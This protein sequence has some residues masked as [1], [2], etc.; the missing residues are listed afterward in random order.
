MKL[1]RILVAL[2]FAMILTAVNAEAQAPPAPLLVSPA[3]GA[4][5]AQPLT[6]SWSA[7]TD[8]RG[9]VANYTWQLGT[10][11]SFTIV[12]AEGF[13]DERNGTPIPATM[14]AVPTTHVFLESQDDGE[15][16]RHGRF[17]RFRV[18]DGTNGDDYRARA[19]AGHAELHRTGQRLPVS[20]A[21][22]LRPQV[23]R[24]PRRAVL[25]AR[26]RR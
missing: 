6:L 26:G 9:P 13:T 2:F 22:V 5:L 15:R 20:R 18:V 1:S 23:D 17:R 4:A 7:V 14:A 16:R 11:S 12:A 19:R 21:R 8:P 24:D 10:T 25:P 3:S